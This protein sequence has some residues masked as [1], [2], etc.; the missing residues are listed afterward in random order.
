M[1]DLA[2]LVVK[3]EAETS[4][5]TAAIQKATDQ[6][7]S[8]SDS[9][10][11]AI[12]ETVKNLLALEAAKK[13]FDF[14]EN[15]IKTMAS[16]ELLSHATG[17]ATDS[18]SQLAFAGK[19]FGVEDISVP[20]ERLAR[21]IGQFEQ[22]NQK[23]INAFAALGIGVRDAQGKVRSADE[24][25]LVIADAVS[26][27]KDGLEKT[28]VVQA[29][30]GRSGADFVALLDQGAEAIKRAKQ[31]AVDLGVSVS[32]PAAQAAHE[33]EQDMIRIG[34]AFEGLFFK[35]IQE[36]LPVFKQLTEQVIE[37]SKNADNTS[38]AVEQIAAGL[39]VIATALTTIGTLF[40]AVGQ[41][42][43][44]SLA[45]I[46][47]E[48][49]AVV[50][51]LSNA[52]VHP[53]DAFGDFIAAQ[54]KLVS[55][56]GESVVGV[57]HTIDAGGKAIENIWDP[58]PIKNWG[59]AIGEA[60]NGW[61][62]SGLKDI[63]IIDNQEIKGIQSAIEALA[64]F[65][66][67]LK[68][69]VATYGLSGAAATVYD[70]T[71]GKLS[72]SVDELDKM[73]PKEAQ[74]AL[75]KLE[76]QGK[77]S[78][79][80]IDAINAA[81]KAG[82]PLGDAFKNE[83]IANAEA[84]DKLKTVDALSKLDSQLLTMTGH[85]EEAAK[86]AF[87]LANRPIKITIETEQAKTAFAGLD[88]GQKIA[89][90]TSQINTLKTQAVA[91]EDAYGK[92]VAEVDA[93]SLASGESNLE[94]LGEE[95]AARQG[96]IAQ[97]ETLFIKAQA[98]AN[99]TGN[100]EAIQ[101]AKDLRDAIDQI[102]F[103]PK[104]VE[105]VDA[106]T[107]A[108][109]RF[110]LAQAEI[111]KTNDDLGLQLTA[112]A[113]QQ[114]EGSLSDLDLMAKQDEARQQA[115]D[116]LEKTRE[117]LLAVNAANPGNPAAL[118]EYKKLGAQV[119]ALQT[120]M[121]ELART[122]RTDLT[123]A[124]SNAFTDFATGAKTA[125]EALRS[126]V[127]DFS[128]QMISLGSKQLFQKLFD[129]TGISSGI[130]SIFGT[131]AKQAAPAI[132]KAA[133]GV[134]D[135]T[136]AAT[137]LST[138]ITT[139]ATAGATEL[140]TG[141]TTAV[142]TGATELGTALE[143]AAT[144]AATEMATAI[145]TAGSTAA[146]EMAAAISAAGASS[147][148]ATGI[149]AVALAAATGGPIPANQLAVVGEKGP[150]LYVDDLGEMTA[151]TATRA[152][153]VVPEDLTHAHVI[154]TDGPEYIKPNVSGY[155]IPNDVFVRALADRTAPKP[156]DEP[157]I[158]A[159]TTERVIQNAGALGDSQTRGSRAQGESER[160]LSAP[161]I[162]RK[163]EF[164][165]P[166]S[167]IELDTGPAA[168]SAAQVPPLPLA[169]VIDITP[170]IAARLPQPQSEV[171]VLSRELN[172][173]SPRAGA[174]VGQPLVSTPTP[175]AQPDIFTQPEAP[176][177]SQ[178]LQVPALPPQPAEELPSELSAVPSVSVNVAQPPVVASAP[179][180]DLPASEQVQQQVIALLQPAL[181]SVPE[182]AVAQ[183]APTQAAIENVVRETA[184]VS[185]ETSVKAASDAKLTR[186]P[187]P[188]IAVPPRSTAES[189]SVPKL[190]TLS[191]VVAFPVPSQPALPSPSTVS[192]PEAATAERAVSNVLAFPTPAKSEAP[193]SVSI[194]IPE[195]PTEAALPTSE[196]AATSN[197]ITFPVPSAPPQVSD[198]EFSAAT[199]DAAA[200][201]PSA[202]DRLD[203]AIQRAD[204][205]ALPM[206]LDQPTSAMI[207][208]FEKI[209]KHEQ[210]LDMLSAHEYEELLTDRYLEKRQ[211]GGRV[212]AGTPY[213]VGEGGVPELMVPDSN[214]TIMSSWDNSENNRSTIVNQT[215]HF[216]IS[217]ATGKVDRAS[218]GQ[219]AARTALSV[220]MASGRNN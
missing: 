184:S 153:T 104:I 102:Q 55:D 181:P 169:P 115:I 6:I 73:N 200:A 210:S 192:I 51:Y 77:L 7:G 209:V 27:Y 138:A 17:I 50:D 95:A 198:R 44:S 109:K 114:S 90:V 9:V 162:S 165:S 213:L 151:A 163:P 205:P 113:K 204:A 202:P 170:L 66:E 105:G 136:A 173:E 149:E 150:E 99:A 112:L 207:V 194:N 166:V 15:I 143:T 154:G 36:V 171:T 182:P 168:P 126:F 156:A 152:G 139:A 98:L 103:S 148:A 57:F 79:A 214:G 32:S 111:K 25:F 176:S 190:E 118:D 2:S 140:G 29:L 137:S 212:N 147:G 52:W 38:S 41:G 178:S 47:S 5:Y 116:Q 56:Y 135:T 80:S 141:I 106:A 167:T 68:E 179:Q 208:K 100:K 88:D 20:F 54:K 65:N 78:A 43:G 75:E 193:P 53:L 180:P 206:A 63:H 124:A 161:E 122:I 40:Q 120:Q 177:A 92:K 16:F 46:V 8:F 86:A 134:A 64:T 132:T 142:T 89:E 158:P 1:T 121:G 220:Q 70:V 101:Q 35:A 94:A 159:A 196:K 160:I 199:L 172:G 97:L 164:R 218:Q 58:A 19:L 72:A 10:G 33:F 197:V 93:S 187:E 146:A 203:S 71:L 211:S 188:T 14:T 128:R 183:L 13:A 69:Q 119:N 24:E 22:G 87:D 133:S 49:K 31:E 85:L 144:T 37:F 39:K 84:L 174:S 81:V 129:T 108:L 155:V 23:A 185:T 217:S 117:E 48:I 28:S 125:S 74:L 83:I 96:A 42:I 215:N 201:L 62:D 195:S 186:Q 60:G 11:A 219:I 26:K 216:H 127:A 34:A 59:L 3:L 189:H 157:S 76:K 61:E 91:I 175:A 145:T 4:Q 12:T 30:F 45:F 21:T 18:L 123:D 191:N 131:A 110:N 107:A 82:I 67:K 130:N